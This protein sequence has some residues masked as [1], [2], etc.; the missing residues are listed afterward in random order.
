MSE[1]TN[2]ILNEI[3]SVSQKLNKN[4]KYIETLGLN[5]EEIKMLNNYIE[6][7]Q[8]ENEYNKYILTEFE[9]WLE[10]IY[11]YI[12]STD[13]KKIIREYYFIFNVAE[14][15]VMLNTIEFVARKLQE[16]KEGK[17]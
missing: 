11:D 12:G 7:L 13:V 16:L 5:K 14:I 9:K 6:Q 4:N 15:N 3:K 2:N 8:Q 10:D 17:K 1:E